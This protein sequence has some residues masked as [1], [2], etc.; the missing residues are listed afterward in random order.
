MSEPR[1][2]HPVVQVS[3]NARMPADSIPFCNIRNG[4]WVDCVAASAN[5]TPPPSQTGPARL[6]TASSGSVASV[7]PAERSFAGMNERL[8]R[9]MAAPTRA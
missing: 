5:T 6:A 3:T 2:A 4:S 7:G 9:N 1:S 8:S